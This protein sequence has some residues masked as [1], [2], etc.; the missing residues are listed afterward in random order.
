MNQCPSHQTTGDGRKRW[1]SSSIGACE[2]GELWLGVRQWMISLLGTEKDTPMSGPFAA[3]V[4]DRFY[5]R[6]ILPL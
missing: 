6:R 4:E 3:M 1:F 5:R 2:G